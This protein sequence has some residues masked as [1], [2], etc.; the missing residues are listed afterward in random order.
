MKNKYFNK[1]ASEK[2]YLIVSLILGLIVIGLVSYFIYQEYFTSDDMDWEQCKQSILLRSQNLPRILK[3]GQ[4]KAFPFQC[5]TK[6]VNIDFKDYEKA[7]KLI[8]NEMAKCWSLFEQGKTPLYS[9][10]FAGAEDIYCFDCTRI[11]FNADV[12]SYYSGD[13]PYY[14]KYM[15][16]KL[17]GNTCFNWR[18]YLDEDFNSGLTYFQYIYGEANPKGSILRK[19]AF[20]T[21][22]TTAAG[23]KYEPKFTNG[24]V[25]DNTFDSSKGDILITMNYRMSRIKWYVI[26]EGPVTSAINQ[27]YNFYSPVEAGYNIL[28]NHQ[29]SQPITCKLETIPA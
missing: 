5:K 18:N 3:I 23:E 19:D 29:T 26:M 2:Y 9:A 20:S 12:K 8:V 22:F 13:C 28:I 10:N 16:K 25:Y 6:V 4:E 11:H 7:G 24:L 1:K 17:G 15:S 21:T 14:D 27:K